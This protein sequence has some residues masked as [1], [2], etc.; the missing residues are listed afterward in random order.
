MV[1]SRRF[2]F[3]L[4]ACVLALGVAAAARA[5]TKGLNQIVTPDIQPTGV[6]SLSAQAQHPGIGNSQEVQLELGLTPQCEVS[7]FHGFDPHEE[8]LGGELNLVQR[9]PHLITIGAVN[10]SSRGGGAQPVVEYGFYSGPDHVIAG[11]IYAQRRTQAIVGYSRQLTDKLQ[12]SADYESGDANAATLGFTVNFTPD[13]QMNP[14]I[15]FTNGSPH[16]VLGYV[17]I[18]WNLPLWKPAK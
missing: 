17:V 9:G 18:S 12:V 4:V 2:P 16:H 6:L 1:S 5:T 3:H 8:I 13:L 10:W 15:Y 14:A 11:A 7:Y